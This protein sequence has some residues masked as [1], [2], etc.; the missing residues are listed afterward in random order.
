MT[1][2]GPRT[3]VI[4]RMKRLTQ[5]AP[6]PEGAPVQGPCW[7]WQGSVTA[8]GYGQVHVRHE[9]GGS[10]HPGF[11]HRVGYE[12][13]LGPVPDGLQLD[14]LCR[15]RHCWNPDHLEPVTPQINALRGVGH[16]AKN[17]AKTQCPAGHDLT[18]PANVYRNPRNPNH[19]QCREC[20]RRNRRA[21]TLR[22]QQRKASTR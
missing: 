4:E 19:R 10:S 21:H 9:A 20:R 5:E 22:T 18:D 1:T 14:H 13:L 7:L 2:L 11:A 17:A 16:A 12:A 3:P 6:A 8:A 15:V